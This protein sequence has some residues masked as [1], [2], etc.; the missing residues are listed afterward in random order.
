MP[1]V[2]S[3]CTISFNFFHTIRETHTFESEASRI[4]QSAAIFGA[5]GGALGAVV[6]VAVVLIVV[7][8]VVVIVT[9]KRKPN[10][11]NA[12]EQGTIHVHDVYADLEIQVTV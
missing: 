11:L 8:T 4:V 2:L 7:V 9:K 12:T 10:H 3:G 6:S 1:N 5:V